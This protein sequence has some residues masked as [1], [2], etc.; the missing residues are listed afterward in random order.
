MKI[1]LG[2]L[3]YFS[4][5]LAWLGGAC[6]LE[7]VAFLHSKYFYKKLFTLKRDNYFLDNY[8]SFQVSG[9]NRRAAGVEI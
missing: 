4:S 6:L 3:F 7:T 8:S 9:V 2:S 5:V 1:V